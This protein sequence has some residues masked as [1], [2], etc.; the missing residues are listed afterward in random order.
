LSSWRRRGCAREGCAREGCAREAREGDG[1]A[2][3]SASRG[4]RPRE[5]DGL[6]RETASRGTRPREGHGREADAVTPS[7]AARIGWDWPARE[8][9]LCASEQRPD[10]TWARGVTT[11]PSRVEERRC[12]TG[13]DGDARA[14]LLEGRGFGSRLRRVPRSRTSGLH[15]VK[16]ARRGG[17]ADVRFQVAWWPGEAGASRAATQV[18]LWCVL[19]QAPEHHSREQFSPAVRDRW[20]FSLNVRCCSAGVLASDDGL[21][22]VL[23][24]EDELRGSPV[25]CLAE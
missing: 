21:F 23:L 1:R 15:R 9:M 8:S 14:L 18:A 20:R 17:R 12:R 11:S 22:D 7:G 13:G 4:R 3:E 19:G 6:A 16:R 10:A 25:M 5:G 24:P 2:R